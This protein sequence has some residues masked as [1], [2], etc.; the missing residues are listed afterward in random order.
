VVDVA[1]RRARE[2]QTR[3]QVAD[4][5]V[6]RGV[7]AQTIETQAPGGPQMDWME[8]VRGMTTVERQEW[9]RKQQSRI[10]HREITLPGQ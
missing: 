8:K 7:Q 9:L 10:R 2:I 1:Q 6:Q 3:Q 5:N 4:Q